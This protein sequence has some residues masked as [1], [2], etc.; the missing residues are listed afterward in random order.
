M[1]GIVSN[2]AALTGVDFPARHTVDVQALVDAAGGRVHARASVV[3]ETALTPEAAIF[4]DP[5]QI[6]LALTN[7]I[8]NSVQAIQ[9]EGRIR[10]MCQHVGRETQITIADDGL[11]M[12]EE[13]RARVFEPLFTAASHRVGIGLTAVQR[14]VGASGGTVKV[15]SAP[16]TGATVTLTFPRHQG[17]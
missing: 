2:L 6:R 5:S 10:I 9:G 8:N 3:I 11:G 16:G 13:V 7:I 17:R 4:C 15:E 1:D 14:P 12:P